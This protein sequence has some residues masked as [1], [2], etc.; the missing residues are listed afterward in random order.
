VRSQPRRPTIL[1]AA[2]KK[3]GQQ[4]EGGDSAPLVRLHLESC[5]QLWSPASSSGALHPALEPSAQERHGAVGSG[6]REG[7]QK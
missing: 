7:P 3:C 6:S 1:W 4:F 2:S 5:I